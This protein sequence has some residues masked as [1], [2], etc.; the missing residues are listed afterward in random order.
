[1]MRS[2]HLVE[3]LLL[4]Y[5][6]DQDELNSEVIFITMVASNGRRESCHRK[7]EALNMFFDVVM[8][9]LTL[10]RIGDRG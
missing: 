10:Y 1:M 8:K 2:F 6:A 3:D 9:V 4:V 7:S 5:V